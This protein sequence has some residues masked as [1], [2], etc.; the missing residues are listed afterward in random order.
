MVLGIPD[1]YTTVYRDP[2]T[3]G[4]TTFVKRVWGEKGGRE[5]TALDDCSLWTVIFGT[6]M[7]FFPSAGGR[8]FPDLKGAM[9]GL[10]PPRKVRAIFRALHVSKDFMFSACGTDF[11]S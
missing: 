6:G 4:S 5:Q 1:S 2:S 7:C 10:R 9:Y 3:M 11:W 8:T